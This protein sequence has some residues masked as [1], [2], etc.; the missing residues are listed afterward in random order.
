MA[1]SSQ[2]STPLL[3]IVL[4]GLAGYV[5]YTGTGIDAVGLQGMSARDARI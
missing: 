2:K 5:A 3:V 4:A 1:L